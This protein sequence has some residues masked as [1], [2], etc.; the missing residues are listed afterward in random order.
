MIAFVGTFTPGAPKGRR[1]T[2]GPSLFPGTESADRLDGCSVLNIRSELRSW[3]K[4][5]TM[6]CRR[7]PWKNWHG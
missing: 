7:C 1:E 6:G 2:G 4:C 3:E 5:R